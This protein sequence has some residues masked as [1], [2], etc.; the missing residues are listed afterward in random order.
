MCDAYHILNI[1]LSCIQNE[2]YPKKP[3]LDS[4]GRIVHC[5]TD[6]LNVDINPT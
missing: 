5:L 1:S 2:D 6:P 4:I 3:D